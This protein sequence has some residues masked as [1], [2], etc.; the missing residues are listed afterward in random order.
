VVFREV[1]GM[2]E[3]ND[4][5]PLKIIATTTYTITLELNSTSFS[6]YQRQGIVENVKVPKKVEFH[7]WAQSYRNPVASSAF[8][9]LETPDLAKFGRSEQLH[10]ALMGINEFATANKRYP[11]TEDVKHV[12][13]LANSFAKT[14]GFEIEIEE[15]VFT[16]AVSWAGCSISPVCAF[17]GGI[18]AQEIVK[19]TGKYSPMKQ[20]LHFDIFETLPRG[21]VNRATSGSRYDDQ[22]TIYGQEL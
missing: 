19:Y 1:E 2:T 5:K 10:A 8:G 7:S 16:K 4:T 11:T 3:I 15:P 13:E 21:E 22:I 14:S 6:D 12:M 9:M 17:F 20:W 18:M